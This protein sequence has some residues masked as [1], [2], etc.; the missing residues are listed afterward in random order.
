MDPTEALH[1]VQMDDYRN[2][3]RSY[4][5]YDRS[6]Q[7]QFAGMYAAA[8]N[9]KLFETNGNSEIFDMTEGRVVPLN[10]PY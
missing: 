5:H 1:V 8:R 2:A 4:N 10:K 6:A 7:S 3:K 9:G